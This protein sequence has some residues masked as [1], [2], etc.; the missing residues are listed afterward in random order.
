MKALLRNNTNTILYS[1][2]FHRVFSNFFCNSPRT[3]CYG[4]SSVVSF[5]SCNSFSEILTSVWETVCER[6]IFHN[7]NVAKYHCRIFR[8]VTSN[9]IKPC[10]HCSRDGERAE[11]HK[12]FITPKS[13][14]RRFNSGGGGFLLQSIC[15]TL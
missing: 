9:S 5:I 4:R 8:K 15:L 6:S 7:T 10:C 11:I 14:K 3:V 1:V 2:S 13:I 12:K